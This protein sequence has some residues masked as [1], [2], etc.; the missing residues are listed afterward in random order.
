MPR[1]RENTDV[2]ILVP[3]FGQHDLDESIGLL[4]INPKRY[5]SW[6]R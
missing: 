2:A 4:L 6:I 5:S 3:G 1:G